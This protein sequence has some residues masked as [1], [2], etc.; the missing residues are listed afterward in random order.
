MIYN[1]ANKYK[2]EILYTDHMRWMSLI[3][4]LACFVML[5]KFGSTSVLAAARRTTVTT[6]RF[7]SEEWKKNVLIANEKLCKPLSVSEAKKLG[8]KGEIILED[9]ILLDRYME[10]LEIAESRKQIP[11]HIPYDV[12]LFFFA[13]RGSITAA[14]AVFSRIHM[15]NE[16]MMTE[17]TT[18]AYIDGLVQFG[19]FGR[20]FGVYSLSKS[21]NE[22]LR[23]SAY[24]TLLYGAVRDGK[25]AEAK[26]IVQDC[27]DRFIPP[28]IRD[29]IVP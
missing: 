28:E 25:F 2:I 23:A 10:E 16:E 26:Q 13:A 12:L 21:N 11:N 24:G 9:E 29:R 22:Q 27:K 20:A 4:F 18:E 1:Y 17:K 5:R 15:K 6:Q 14:N 3:I 19:D 7:I 8:P